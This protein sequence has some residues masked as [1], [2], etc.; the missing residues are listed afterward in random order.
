M[1]HCPQSSMWQADLGLPSLLEWT[2]FQQAFILPKMLKLFEALSYKIAQPTNKKQNAPRKKG[3]LGLG[4]V[5][6]Q[7][8]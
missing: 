4:S 5:K 2:L 1:V 6:P 7:E 3:T 8:Q